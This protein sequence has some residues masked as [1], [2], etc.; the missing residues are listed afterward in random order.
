M[1]AR[2]R[3]KAA[4]ATSVRLDDELAKKLEALAAAMDRSKTW[5]IERAV[6]RYVEEQAWQIE[7]IQEAYKSY[8]DGT[9]KIVPHTEVMERLEARIETRLTQ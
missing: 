9:A 6:Q 5:I 7:A 2:T 8:Q 3:T 4:F 1:E